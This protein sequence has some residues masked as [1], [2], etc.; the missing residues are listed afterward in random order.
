MKRLCLLLAVVAAAGGFVGWL[1]SAGRPNPAFAETPSAD[2]PGAA[3]QPPA[4]AEGAEAGIKAI[5]A[6]YI[7]AFNAADA[8]AAASLTARSWSLKW[9]RT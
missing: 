6:E 4:K 2:P 7:K 9:F 3:A 1:K 8:K 5:T